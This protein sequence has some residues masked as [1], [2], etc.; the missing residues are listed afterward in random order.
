MVK[1]ATSKSPSGR[2]KRKSGAARDRLVIT[3]KDPDRVYR[4]ISSDPSRIHEFE[5]MGYRIEN[6]AD[7]LP[8]GLRTD[9]GSTAD[10]SLPVGA[11]RN[12]ILV[13]LDK[14]EYDA[15]QKDKAEHVDSTEAA[16]KPNIS[17]GQ[18]GHVIVTR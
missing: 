14:D 11:G 7:H 2:L 15:A 13:S 12:H 3:N 8:K 9:Q 5:Q 1:E 17:E 18:Y 6:I 16:M 10:N 4:I